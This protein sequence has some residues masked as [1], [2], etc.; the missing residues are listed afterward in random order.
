[1]LSPLPFNI[2]NTFYPPLSLWY[3]C[4]LH[5]IFQKS[6]LTNKTDLRA[7]YMLFI[8]LNNLFLLNKK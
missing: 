3:E 8:S 4:V 2:K 6:H 7:K 1:M 5:S